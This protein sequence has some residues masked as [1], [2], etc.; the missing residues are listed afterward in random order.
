MP[1]P[2]NADIGYTAQIR[3]VPSVVASAF[4]IGLVA[5][6]LAAILPALRVARAN[7]VDALRQNV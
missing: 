3:L 6:V 1:P 4:A 2:P 7:V 5:T